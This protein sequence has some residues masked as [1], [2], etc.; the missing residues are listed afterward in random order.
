[1][2]TSRAEHRL[3]LRHDNA[4][5][6]LTPR[7][8]DLGLIGSGHATIFR[9]KAASL[10]AAQEYVRE[11]KRDG[12]RLNQWLKRPEATYALLEGEERSRFSDEIWF[13]VETDLKYDGYIR[14]QEEAVVAAGKL[15]GKRIPLW[16]DFLAIRGLRNEARQKLHSIKPETLGQATR[17]SGITPADV[18]LLSVWIEK[19]REPQADAVD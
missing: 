9:D 14:R 13:L 8:M 6:R 16:V 10:S 15:D 11:A 18:A 19:R 7:A 17:I 2:F 3:L 4:D 1:M 5:L 12:I